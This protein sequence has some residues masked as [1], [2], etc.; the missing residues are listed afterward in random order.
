M[1]KVACALTLVAAL[2]L[3]GAARA[4][5]PVGVYALVDKVVLEP[6]QKSPTRIQVWGTFAV[7]KG[8]EK[9]ALRYG[10]PVQGYLYY[11]LKED[12]RELCRRDWAGLKKVA[13]TGQC[14]AFGE[15]G[16]ALSRVRQPDEKPKGPDVYPL[17]EGLIKIRASDPQA[18]LLKKRSAS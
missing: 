16:L 10:A 12:E 17:A 5:G 9:G 18:K 6:N 15:V 11:T 3:G 8:G 7:A 13:G 14:V 2:G 4:S 1:R